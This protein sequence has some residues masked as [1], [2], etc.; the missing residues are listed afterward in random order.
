MT[1]RAEVTR[2]MERAWR[3]LLDGLSL[4]QCPGCGVG[5]QL[6]TTGH[7]TYCLRCTERELGLTA[8]EN[9]RRIEAKMTV[10]QWLKR[11]VDEPYPEPKP[12]AYRRR[13]QPWGGW[14][15][16][17]RVRTARP[18][19]QCGALTNKGRRPNKPLLCIDCGLT[20]AVLAARAMG[21]KEGPA[22][23]AWLANPGK[24]AATVP[25]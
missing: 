24:G 14:G 20:N 22:W 9:G 11:P 15:M 23:E 3:A 2:T 19:E 16:P 25:R 10:G 4:G 1:T 21:D 7:V 12:S 8:E 18:C 5:T 17:R 13:V 6:S